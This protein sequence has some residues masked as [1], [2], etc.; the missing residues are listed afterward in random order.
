MCVALGSV[1]YSASAA[2]EGEP[3]SDVLVIK[4][5]SEGPYHSMPRAA[6]LVCL[7]FVI[8]SFMLGPRLTFASAMSPQSSDTA[9]NFE[10]VA[11]QAI[12]AREAGKMNEAISKY[13]AGVKMRPNW[14][15]GWWYLGTLLY[16][17]DQCGEAI[18]ALRRVVELDANVSAGWA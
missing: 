17:T 4:Q 12:A 18:P 10:T 6:S 11:A 7:G 16:D 9:E 2:C 3:L 5:P 1:L 8:L 13:R 15:E 14:E